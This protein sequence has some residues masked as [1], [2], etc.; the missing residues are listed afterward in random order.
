MDTIH[1]LLN[2][3]SWARLEAPVPNDEER[4][5]LFR[6]A[7]RAPDHGLLRPWKFLTIEGEARARLGDLFV[8]VLQPET[9]EQQ[10]KLRN[11]PLRAPLIIVA[12]TTFKEHP[13][14]PPVEQIGSTAAAVQN[15]SL[16]AYA[17]GYATIWRT[18]EPAFNGSIKKGLGLNETDE[19][20]GYIYIGTPTV[21]DRKVPELDPADF[22]SEWTGS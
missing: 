12:A 11:A 3:T 20:V 18:G 17:M 14:V 6:A 9:P 15:I 2:R 13:K 19:I 5:L 4:E 8:D 22:V 1:A 21:T 10:E 7:L 16:A